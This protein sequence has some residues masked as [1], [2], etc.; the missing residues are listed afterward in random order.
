MMTPAL[1]NP[2]GRRESNHLAAGKTGLSSAW[3]SLAASEQKSFGAAQDFLL[4]RVQV[5]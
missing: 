2:N 4:R 1:R 5:L 3:I